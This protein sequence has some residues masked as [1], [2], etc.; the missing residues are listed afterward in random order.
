M[1]SLNVCP[2]FGLTSIEQSPNQSPPGAQQLDFPEFLDM[3]H[4]EHTELLILL[5]AVVVVVTGTVVGT[6]VTVV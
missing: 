1:P 5:V 2:K 4:L 3:P 6:V